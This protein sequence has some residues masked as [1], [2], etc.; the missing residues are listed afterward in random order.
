MIIEKC[1]A[2]FDMNVLSIFAYYAVGKFPAISAGIETAGKTY[3]KGE[4]KCGEIQRKNDYV[5]DGIS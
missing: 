3:I 4:C 2:Q 1:V 5:N